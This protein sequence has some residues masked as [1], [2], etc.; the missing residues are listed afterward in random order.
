M[1]DTERTPNVYL[2]RGLRDLGR[3]GRKN[4]W[5][6]KERDFISVEDTDPHILEEQSVLSR[7]NK[8]DICIYIHHRDATN[9]KGHK[10]S[11]KSER[12]KTDYL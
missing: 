2:I 10:K 9:T 3:I 5:R 4:L 6:Y 11:L 7:V 12:E 1:T 8:K